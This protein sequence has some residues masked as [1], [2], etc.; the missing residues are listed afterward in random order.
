MGTILAA[1]H[2]NCNLNR[3]S[4]KDAQGK[5]KLRV[6]YR[7]FKEGEGTVREARVKQD[8]GT[9]FGYFLV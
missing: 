3:E 8:F 2:F 6:A 1:L 7:K 4:L 5:T 9:S